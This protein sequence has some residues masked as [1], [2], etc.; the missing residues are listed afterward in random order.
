MKLTE[1]NSI[2]LH[3]SISHRVHVESKFLLFRIWKESS[4]VIANWRGLALHS[5][6]KSRND[7]T[8]LINKITLSLKLTH[9]DTMAN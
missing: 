4:K 8:F 7:M 2:L 6:L 9:L 5:L 1:L 3:H